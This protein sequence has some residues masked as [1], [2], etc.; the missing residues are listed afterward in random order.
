MK[1][2]SL[3]HELELDEKSFGWLEDSSAYRSDF[4]YLKEF[5]ESNGYLYIKNFFPRNIIVEARQSLLK[6]LSEKDIFNLDHP[7]TLI[8]GVLKEGI[9]PKFD[10]ESWKNNPTLNRVVFGPEVKEFYTKFLGGDIR[11][12]DYIWLRTMGK[13]NGTA[14]HCDIVYMGRG[15]HDLYTAWI[16]YSDVSLEMGGLMILE[17]SQLQSDRIKKYLESDVDTYCENI[18]NIDGWK[19]EGQ[20]TNNPVSL[21][22]KLGNRWLT[23]TFEMGDLLTFKMNTVHGSID[24]QTQNIRLSTDTRYQRADEPIDERW[25]GVDPIGHGKDGKKGLI[26]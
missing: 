3:G 22:Q 1:L 24:N 4:G 2:T 9:H 21:R 19:H 18:P 14:P 23:S 12:F 16:P 13:G 17:K 10:S 6:K 5:M 25:I 20:L 15:T 8:D 7:N 26:C 11:H